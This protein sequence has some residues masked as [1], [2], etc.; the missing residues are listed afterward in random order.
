MPFV[1]E[2]ALRVERRAEQMG[3]EALPVPVW[4]GAHLGLRLRGA[5]CPPQTARGRVQQTPLRNGR[6]TSVRRASTRSRCDGN[7]TKNRGRK[8]RRYLARA[9]AYTTQRMPG[10][11]LLCAELARR[12]RLAALAALVAAVS[13]S[14]SSSRRPRAPICSSTAAGDRDRSARTSP[15]SNG[16]R[17]AAGP[18]PRPD[19]AAAA[20]SSQFAS[21]A[22]SSRS[23]AAAASTDRTSATTRCR[24][25]RARP[26]RATRTARPGAR[27][28]RRRRTIRARR[29]STR[30]SSRQT[31]THIDMIET[32]RYEIVL[33]DRPLRGRR[34][35]HAHVRPRAG[36]QARGVGGDACAPAAT[37]EPPPKP[38]P[39]PAACE[40]PGDP[41]RLEVRPSKKLLRT[42]ETFQFRA[43]V[44][45]DKGCATKTPTTWKMQRRAR[46]PA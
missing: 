26:T 3:V 30:W 6:E 37:R 28:A 40:S 27:A 16:C 29:S 22:T 43:L 1:R 13:A 41:T 36:R 5:R 17:T 19:D 2:E 38:E 24:R 14:S 8:S 9:P 15:S 7:T 23:S 44:L 32:G 25:S 31:D 18:P 10:R 20:R 34:E 21:K 12:R 42:G 35:A 45:D 46:P 39:K 33:D 11:V 4:D